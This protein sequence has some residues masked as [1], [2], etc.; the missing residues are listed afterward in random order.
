MLR[1]PLCELLGIDVPI[2]LAPFGPW[3]EVELCAEVCE[4]GGLGSVGTAVRSPAELETAPNSVDPAEVGP[5]FIAAALTGG[6]HELLPFAGQSAALVN[7]IVSARELMTRLVD[8]AEAALGRAASWV[9]VA[10][11]DR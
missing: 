2:V 8:E 3:D 11:R 6:G 9:G 5:A 4:A 10:G 7:D 1:T